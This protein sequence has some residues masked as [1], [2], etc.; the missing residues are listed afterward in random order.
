MSVVSGPSYLSFSDVDLDQTAVEIKPVNG[1]VHGWFLSNTTSSKVY[2]KLYET[3]PTVGTTTPLVTLQV[4]ANGSA[5][6]EFLRGIS[7]S[8]GIWAACTSSMAVS[9]TT[10]PGANA[11][12][13]NIFYL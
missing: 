2:V 11:C 4:P 6:Q 5:N 8:S 3:S 13:A 7:F 10:D 12:I 9:D 1:Q